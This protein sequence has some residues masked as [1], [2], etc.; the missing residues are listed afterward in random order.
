MPLIEDTIAGLPPFDNATDIA[1]QVRAHWNALTKPR[2]SLGRLETEVLRLAQIQGDPKPRVHRAAVYVFCGDHGITEENV[3]AYPQAVTREMMKNF[4]AGGAAINVLCRRGAMETVVVDAGVCGEKIEGVLDRR[5]A[6]GT[7][8]FLKRP[9]MDEAQV[10]AAME[11]GIELSQDAARRFDV[12]GLGEMGIGNS[13][14]A[15]A[16]LSAFLGIHPENSAGRGAGLDD[17]GLAHKRSVVTEALSRHA[18]YVQQTKPIEILAL[19]GGFEIA[20]MA[21]FILGAASRRL[22]VVVD[23]FICGAAFLA[24]WKLCPRLL[25]FVIFA[26]RSAEPGHTLLL[27]SLGRKPLLDLELRLGEGTG[28]AMAIALLRSAVYLYREMATFSQAS[29]SDTIL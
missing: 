28:A 22:P 23:G 16:L 8:N 27:D 7:R 19:F 14:S 5:I 1:D 6:Q 17:G 3:S 2:G 12:V 21:G 9:A 15:S 26:H 24:A 13:T 10:R 20:M 18:A 29:V 11:A 4:V 25:D